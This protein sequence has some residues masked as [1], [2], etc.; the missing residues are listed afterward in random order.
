LTRKTDP[1]GDPIDERPFP[2]QAR[3]GHPPEFAEPGDD[4]Y[5]R[6]LHREEAEQADDQ[7]DDDERPE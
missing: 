2:V 1:A 6:G 7:N 5:L 3:L 4:S